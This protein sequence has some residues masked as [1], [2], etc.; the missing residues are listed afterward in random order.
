[1]S[2]IIHSLAHVVING[3]G[4]M[5]LVSVAGGLLQV[6]SSGT[7]ASEDQSQCRGAGWRFN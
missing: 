5:Q 7:C 6:S 3:A 1:M 4:V 2:F